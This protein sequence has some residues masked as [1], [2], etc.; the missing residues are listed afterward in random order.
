MSK[1]IGFRTPSTPFPQPNVTSHCEDGVTYHEIAGRS[2]YERFEQL[3]DGYTW[4]GQALDGMWAC[5]GCGFVVEPI[6]EPERVPDEQYMKLL[7]IVK[8]L[9]EAYPC[10]HGDDMRHWCSL[11]DAELPLKPEDHEPDCPWRM[12]IEVLK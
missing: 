12:A 8:A 7:E 11:C 9:A 5:V 2:H 3:P 6:F 1:P 10:A 4:H